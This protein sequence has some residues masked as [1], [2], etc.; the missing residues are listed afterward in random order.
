MTVS[1]SFSAGSKHGFGQWEILC[2]DLPLSLKLRR[3]KAIAPWLPYPTYLA[4][5]SRSYKDKTRP[6]TADPSHPCN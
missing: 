6:N 1:I 2:H 3:N 5:F 4:I